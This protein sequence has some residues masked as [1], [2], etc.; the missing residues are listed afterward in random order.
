MKMTRA[1]L[2]LLAAALLAFGRPAMADAAEA[3]LSIISVVGSATIEETPDSAHLM[4]GVQSA[5]RAAIT[6]LK[7]NKEAAAR[8]LDSLSAKGIAAADIQTVAFS[9]TPMYERSERPAGKTTISGYTVVHQFGV[10][11]RDLDSLGTVLD[12]AIKAGANLAGSVSFALAEPEPLRAAARRAAV[13]DGQRKAALL[14]EAAGVRLGRLISLNEA[15]QP[16]PIM[17]QNRAVMMNV[18]SAVPVMPG[19]EAISATVE[20]VFQIE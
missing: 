3:P 12:T 5:A 1:T 20:M 8:L 16:G 17:P 2:L 13:A 11:V 10:L 15:G 6:A 4:L 9:V 7:E 19:R 14:A 18:E